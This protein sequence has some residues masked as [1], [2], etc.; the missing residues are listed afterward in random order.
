M[1]KL[2]VSREFVIFVSS[3]TVKCWR[4]HLCCDLC[5]PCAVL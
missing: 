2:T 1:P 3:R 5:L 4:W